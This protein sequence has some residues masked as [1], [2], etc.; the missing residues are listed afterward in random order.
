M[1]N[2]SVFQQP[3]NIYVLHF[4]SVLPPWNLGCPCTVLPVSE[5]GAS[6]LHSV[7]ATLFSQHRSLLTP[8]QNCAPRIFMAEQGLENLDGSQFGLARFK[9]NFQTTT[10]AIC[11]NDNFFLLIRSYKHCIFLISQ[12]LPVWNKLNLSEAPT[13]GE[14][15]LFLCPFAHLCKRASPDTIGSTNRRLARHSFVSWTKY[16]FDVLLP[17][18]I[19]TS[20]SNLPFLGGTEA[21]ISDREIET[22]SKKTPETTL[23]KTDQSLTC[24][25]SKLHKEKRVFLLQADPAD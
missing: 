16:V 15:C 7:F 23:R 6:A 4:Y 18:L 19:F 5:S 9:P 25:N 17:S 12:V 2:V 1:T 13:G 10:P 3:S 21:A 11:Q 14:V 22:V 20:H 8:G 24:S